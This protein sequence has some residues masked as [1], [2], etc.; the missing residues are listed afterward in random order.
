MAPT[1]TSLL[2]GIAAGS[3]VAAVAAANA[4]FVPAQAQT[5]T[6]PC[7][8]SSPVEII[9]GSNPTSPRG[10]LT[11]CQCGVQSCAVLNDQALQCSK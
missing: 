2:L 1:K 8:C 10:W 5:G 7:T 4:T 11:N 9:A 3:V 6:A